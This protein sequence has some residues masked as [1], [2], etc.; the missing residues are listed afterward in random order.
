MNWKWMNFLLY[1]MTFVTNTRNLNWNWNTYMEVCSRTRITS[2]EFSTSQLNR[3]PIDWKK[4]KILISVVGLVWTY[5]DKP[6]V[7]C[8]INCWLNA[9]RTMNYLSENP[10]RKTNSSRKF[11][12]RKSY[13]FL[14]FNSILKLNRIIVQVVIFK[15]LT[16][17]RRISKTDKTITIFIVK[18]L[19]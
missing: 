10:I 16:L 3:Q 4:Y 12:C 9:S 5:F 15:N 6:N 2:I 7:H 1:F 13:F 18:M 19:N 17:A 11:K 14:E 8:T